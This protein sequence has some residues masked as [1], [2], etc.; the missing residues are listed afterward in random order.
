LKA[1]EQQIQCPHCGESLLPFE[2][3]EAGGWQ[4]DFHLACF[5]DDCPYY[6]RGWERMQAQYSV[7]CSYRY[8]VDPATGAPSPL[9]VWSPTALRDRIL[10]A[11]V[12]VTR[13]DEDQK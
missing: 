9:A 11:D 3:P 7:R 1:P 2:L 10:D 5:N 13:D 4:T 12:T 6:E 8:R